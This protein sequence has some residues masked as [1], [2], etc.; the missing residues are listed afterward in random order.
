MMQ[1][2]P[3]AFLRS[4]VAITALQCG[5]AASLHMHKDAFTSVMKFFKDLAHAPFDNYIVRTL[6][7]H[8]VLQGHIPFDIYIVRTVHVHVLIHD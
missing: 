2:C 7:V 3:L 5:L 1:R 6:H 8:E 4:P